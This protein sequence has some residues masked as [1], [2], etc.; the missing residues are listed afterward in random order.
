MK[1]RARRCL[2][3][4]LVAATT[5]GV[6][7][8]SSAAAVRRRGNPY[9]LA[10]GCFSLSSFSVHRLVARTGN[11]Y[12]ASARRLSHAYRLYLQPTALGRYLLL[13]RDHALIGV[14]AQGNVGPA[15]DPSD[16][17]VWR[18]GAT[19]GGAF[20]LR[21]LST[22][23]A[24][25]VARNGHVVLTDSHTATSARRF[26]FRRTR[27]CARP[28]EAQVNARGR[29][30]HGASAS[31]TVNGT[32]DAHTHLTAFEFIGGDFH[33]GRP[34]HPFGVTFALPDC[35]SIQGPNG[36][37]APV[38]NFVDY[39]EPEH[40]HDTVGWPTFHDWPGPA[41]LS[42]EG[43]YYTGLRRAWLAGVRIIVTDLVDNE[44]LCTIMTMKRN[45]CNDMASV[46]I[47][48]RDAYALQNYVD[49][50]S[51]GPG[52]GWFRV[53]KNPFQARRVINQGKIAVVLG[54]E[55]SRIFG[56]GEHNGV[57]ECDKSQ[58]NRGL[59]EVRRLGVS[60]FYPVHKFDNA[61]GGT[62]MDGGTT[63]LV[64]NG[65][66]HLETGQ[67]WDIETCKGSA[68]DSE[69]LTPPGGGIPPALA[70]PPFDQL[71]PVGTVLPAYPSG[72][73]CNKR[74][75]TELGAYLVNRMIT[76][77]FIVEV[78][79][80]DV[81][82]GNK[83]LELIEKRHYS[84]VV[85]PHDW[86]SP[87][88]YPRIYR[89]GGFIN[90]IAG[91]SPES[92]VGEWRADRKIRDRRYLFGFGFGSDINGLA[93]QSE[94]TNRHPIR[95][96]FRSHTGQVSFG[97]ERWGQRV[98]DLNVDGLSNYG[99]YADWLQELRILGGRQMMAD[100]FR[101]AESYLQT[102]ERA[103]GVPL[104]HCRP[105]GERFTHAGLGRLGL[106]AGSQTLLYRAGQPSS[107]PGRSF[108]YCVRGGGRAAVVFSARGRAVLVASTA[109]GDR[110]AGVGPGASAGGL[111]GRTTSAGGGVLVGSG[112]PGASRFVYG[113]HG[114]RVR[115][116][117]V[118]AGSEVGSARRL[119]ADL[120]A[121]GLR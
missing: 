19:R 7:I 82:T 56:C 91:S 40:P 20:V 101:G 36:S 13:G 69:Q 42:Y 38:Q 43:T 30:F 28:A 89:T 81:K 10:N 80:M 49:A 83:A 77:H 61:F 67:F 109:R 14:D 102:W 104:G 84:G 34:W 75:L 99:M 72:P 95:Y 22:N 15:A 94:A 4:V 115:W 119:H 48:A 16:S 64:V 110:A 37:A 85:S 118:A 96:P 73:H 105:A 57:S 9:A 107:R 35:A 27:R 65:G 32:I 21:S 52:K 6:A 51:G 76:R 39:G 113:V 90:P 54:I 58:V 45:P 98:F 31:S 60:S 1:S 108:R 117:A 116:V 55:V 106:G 5:V 100:M 111:A 103:Y 74:G 53:V 120:R 63:G 112:A 121:A 3:A 33:C 23:R 11:A 18:V 86:S 66:N 92:F 47:Q 24:L 68:H 41:R 25:A 88:Q 50:Q 87:E 29:A 12:T 114:G 59:D 17:A 97:R 79:H 46:H 26:D 93:H 8:P 71:F 70:G 78:D 44:A 2:V 62:K